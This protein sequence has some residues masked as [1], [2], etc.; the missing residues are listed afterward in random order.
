MTIFSVAV[1]LLLAGSGIELVGV[2]LFMLNYFCL[3]HENFVISWNVF[4]TDAFE[5]NI[6]DETK[7]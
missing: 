3:F 7:P 1:E 5:E 6:I 2:A 4:I